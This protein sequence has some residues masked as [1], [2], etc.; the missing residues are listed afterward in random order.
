MN[1]LDEYS[2]FSLNTL[3]CI[4]DSAEPAT[5]FGGFP[6]FR[7]LFKGASLGTSVGL[8]GGDECFLLDFFLLVYTGIRV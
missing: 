4:I 7:K 8:G 5:A 1:G 2:E 3:H 6:S